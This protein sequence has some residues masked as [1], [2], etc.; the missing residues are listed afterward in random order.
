MSVQVVNV[1]LRKYKQVRFNEFPLLVR[2]EEIYPVKLCS[3][4]A[5]SLT[6]S[7]VCAM[8]FTLPCSQTCHKRRLKS[9]RSS[10]TGRS[11][12]PSPMAAPTSPARRRPLS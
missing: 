8:E 11:S 6:S 2:A 1:Q 12:P 9:G 10:A 4:R 3:G 7:S 5:S